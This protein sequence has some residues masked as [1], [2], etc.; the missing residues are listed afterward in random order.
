MDADVAFY[1]HFAVDALLV[2]VVALA[3]LAPHIERAFGRGGGRW[4]DLAKTFAATRPM[5]AGALARQN[6]MIG[7]VI[8]RNVMTVGADESGLFLEPGRPLSLVLKQRLLIPWAEIAKTQPAALFW[9]KATTLIIGAPAIATITLQEN[10]FE[11][12]AQP[13][14]SAL[15]KD[16]VTKPAR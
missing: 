4:R 7:P 10:V 15:V 6:V 13:W 2:A 14:L 5:P 1:L 12:L 11:K 9:G 3:W 16:R 8:Y